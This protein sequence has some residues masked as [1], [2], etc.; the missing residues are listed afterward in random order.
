MGCASALQQLTKNSTLL[1][2]P[3]YRRLDRAAK[4]PSSLPTASSLNGI[5]SLGSLIDPRTSRRKRLLAK[6]T[7]QLSPMP[8]ANRRI[9]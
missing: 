1:Q 4:Q 3:T 9:P 2:S 8:G 6:K 7:S 5:L